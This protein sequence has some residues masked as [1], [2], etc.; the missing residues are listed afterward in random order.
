LWYYSF[1]PQVA[2]FIVA[3]DI[4]RYPLRFALYPLLGILELSSATYSTLS[5]APEFAIT[6]AGIL[7]SGLIGLVYLIPISLV[8]VRLLRRK[9]VRGSH[10]LRGY[11]ISLLAAVAMLLLGESMGSSSILAIAS[12]VLVLTALIFTPL[13]LMFELT[14]SM[15][16]SATR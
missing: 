10:V 14:S 15:P 4:M 6:V 7:A 8:M 5:F 12:S 2:D 3:H 16:E 11:T 13:L 9:R 1:S